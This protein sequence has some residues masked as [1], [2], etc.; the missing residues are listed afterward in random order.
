[1]VYL[2]AKVTPVAP[3]AEDEISVR[4]DAFLTKPA[5]SQKILSTI[6]KVLK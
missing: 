1:V 6:E 2:S 3:H 5:T 4:A